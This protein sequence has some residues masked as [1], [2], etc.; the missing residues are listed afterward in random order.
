MKNGLTQR[1]SKTVLTQHRV[2]E[3]KLANVTISTKY[4]T[5]LQRVNSAHEPLV[6]EAFSFLKAAQV[7]GEQWECMKHMDTSSSSSSHC[8][9]HNSVHNSKYR[10]K[11]MIVL[12]LHFQSLLTISYA[13]NCGA[14]KKKSGI[15]IIMTN[16]AKKEVNKCCS[17]TK[18]WKQWRTG[19]HSHVHTHT[20]TH[21]PRQ[22][23]DWYSVLFKTVFTTMKTESCET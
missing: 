20:H 6:S 8:L 18:H 12:V 10:Q 22:V 16:Y 21:K 2:K 23:S 1:G 15:I 3:L 14:K 7:N 13:S 11:Q 9:Y 17:W 5:Q 4:S 19:T